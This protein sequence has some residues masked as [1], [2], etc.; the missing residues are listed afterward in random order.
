MH[1]AFGS[2]LFFFFPQRAKRSQNSVSLS[3]PQQI[4]NRDKSLESDRYSDA[5]LHFTFFTYSSLLIKGV[6]SLTT[7]YQTTP[8]RTLGERGLSSACLIP[9]KTFHH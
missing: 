9:N 3:P 7:A 2:F 5:I 4:H 6:A 1:R 8:D